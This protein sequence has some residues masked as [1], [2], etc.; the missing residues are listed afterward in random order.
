MP[1]DVVENVSFPGQ[2][3]GRLVNSDGC[4][5]GGAGVDAERVIR[6]SSY[7]VALV[8]SPNF[9]YIIAAQSEGVLIYSSRTGGVVQRLPLLHHAGGFAVCPEEQGV[10]HNF[11]AGCL[12]IG[13]DTDPGSLSPDV[14]SR[15]I[16]DATRMH[17]VIASRERVFVFSGSTIVQLTMAPVQSVSLPPVNSFLVFQLELAKKMKFC[18]LLDVPI[19]DYFPM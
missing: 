15:M 2:V 7:P 4:S 8:A 5:L 1:S 11:A 14:C 10:R 12:P 9:P 16:D 3:T 17:T 19:F 13:A 6:F 18:C